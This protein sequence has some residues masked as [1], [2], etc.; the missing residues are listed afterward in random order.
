MIKEKTLN[1]LKN[2]V[3]AFTTLCNRGVRIS[4]RKVSELFKNGQKKCPKITCRKR[5][6]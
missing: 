3:K 6:Y 5:P 1:S 2:R 4:N